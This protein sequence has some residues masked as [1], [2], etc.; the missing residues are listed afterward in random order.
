MSHR[1]GRSIGFALLLA[2]VVLAVVMAAVFSLSPAGVGAHPCEADLIPGDVHC[3]QGGHADAGPHAAMSS[4]F[5]N[6][7]VA[8]TLSANAEAPLNAENK[9]SVD[10]S[11]GSTDAAF[12][13]PSS[14]TNPDPE[15]ANVNISEEFK[16]KITKDTASFFPTER[17]SVRNKVATITIPDSVADPGISGEYSITFSKA[18]GIKTPYYAG[19]SV[20]TVSANVQGDVA[21]EIEVVIEKNKITTVSPSIGSRSTSFTLKGQG[22]PRGTV[23]VF[24]GSDDSL[25]AGEFLGSRNVVNGTFTLSNLSV[26]EKASG[27]SYT[28]RTKD[29]EG[30]PDIAVFKVSVPTTSFEPA[31]AVIGE[32]LTITVADWQ[33][34]DEAIAAVRIGGVDAAF[35]AEPIKGI[36][37]ASATCTHYY[38]LAIPDD[39]AASVEVVVPE[40][41][42][43]G[44]QTV[45]IYDHDQLEYEDNTNPTNPVPCTGNVEPPPGENA[46]NLRLKVSGASP[47][48]RRTI[49]VQTR[50]AADAEALEPGLLQTTN[51][52]DG[53]RDRRLEFKATVPG[54]LENIGDSIVIEFEPSFDLPD[55]S[56]RA[57]QVTIYKGEPT[58]SSPKLIHPKPL[59]TV[60]CSPWRVPPISQEIL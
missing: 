47:I 52:V 42:L 16:V 28:V 23:T 31:T 14:I 58:T 30:E 55:P 18:A 49:T 17:V 54:D 10:F 2:A 15:D 50:E 20:I 39:G 22:Y 9:I 36:E 6:K 43:T 33:P 12:F 13:M 4:Y 29:S 59:S 48:L 37:N 1:T 24:D 34:D 26:G 8:I 57:Q 32:P 5:P 44:M 45:A 41:V 60:K 19:T 25:D 38:G 53:G 7:E 46:R 27:L 11:G 56:P 51:K 21:D 35:G 3:D 40:E